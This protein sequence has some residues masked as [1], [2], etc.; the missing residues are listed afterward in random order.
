MSELTKL[1]IELVEK[2][3]AMRAEIIR[4]RWDESQV[5]ALCCDP[6]EAKS[7]REVVRDA[8]LSAVGSRDPRNRPG[9]FT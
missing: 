6:D 4:R 2:E 3:A 8:L 5:R 9:R 1:L 7:L